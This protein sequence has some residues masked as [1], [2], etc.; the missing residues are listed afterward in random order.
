MADER[1]RNGHAASDIPF[2][3][4]AEMKKKEEKKSDTMC[5]LSC[6]PDCLQPCADIKVFLVFFS[7]LFLFTGAF[8]AY[9]V[10]VMTTLEKRF[11]FPSRD[12]G[13]LMMFNDFTHLAIVVVG[14]Y[15][16]GK[17]NRPRML[18]LSGIVFA[19][20]CFVLSIPHYVFG[21][22]HIEIESGN[23]TQT[24]TWRDTCTDAII[25]NT[26]DTSVDSNNVA[27]AIL[28]I[29]EL[30]V[31]LGGSTMFSLGTSYVDDNVKP[32]DASFYLSISYAVRM[33]G[34]AIGFAVGSYSTRIHVSF[35]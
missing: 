19:L 23:G 11:H 25:P 12:T 10:S 34:P 33:F 28:C 16:G 21:S 35:S 32:E 8:Y 9:F 30:L 26:C 17:A 24:S 2:T 27:Y 14:S 22:G 6:Y 15:F 18:A 3:I 7:L 1:I 29:G 13:I 20:G 4:N 5:G 31:G